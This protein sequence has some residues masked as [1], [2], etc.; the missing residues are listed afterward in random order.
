MDT[1]SV[2]KRI[3]EKGSLHS[4]AVASS[5]A[6]ELFGLEIIAADIHTIKSNTTR[7]L[8]LSAEKE[9]TLNGSP[10]DKASIKFVME[11][12]QG[13]LVSTLNILRDYDLDM[14]KIQSVP[15]ID[16]PWKYGFFIDV[17]FNDLRKF[18]RAMEILEVMTEELKILGTYRNGR[19]LA[20]NRFGA[21][22][23]ART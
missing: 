3:S 18:N 15:V 19:A 5:T 20:E 6:A 7:F 12:K 22:A 2:A 4:A 16:M 14:T 17:V 10:A 11:S 9:K 13:S 8:I 21:V 1:A 23:A